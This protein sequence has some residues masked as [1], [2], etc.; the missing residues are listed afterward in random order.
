MTTRVA[1]TKKKF[2]CSIK[3]APKPR[4]RKPA[5]K[6]F[7]LTG[8]VNRPLLF[9]VSTT[10]VLSKVFMTSYSR[11]VQISVNPNG[12]V[13]KL[14]IQSTF[15]GTEGVRGDK[16]R[17]RRFHGGPQRAV[18]LFSWEHIRELQEEGHPIDAGTTGENL[19][20]A[21]L[22]WD[23]IVPGVQLR[24]G[25]EV[26]LEITSYTTPCTNIR[27]S[28]IDGEFNRIHH[29]LHPGWSRLYAKVLCEGTIHEGD[30]VE[31]L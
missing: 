16:Q 3:K 15:I 11:V 17:N 27:S 13:P 12:G 4:R 1:A 9:C 29:K 2:W 20:I 19:T 10:K 8:V 23:E 21:G 30:A 24:I 26:V 18:C 6:Y 28:F 22:N 31:K 14:R 25:D 5:S 7:K